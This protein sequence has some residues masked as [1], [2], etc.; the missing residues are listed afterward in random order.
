MPQLRTRRIIEGGIYNMRPAHECAELGIDTN[1]TAN[2]RD[3]ML[4]VI[5]KV[6][7]RTC[8]WQV[9]TSV[10][11]TS[12][13]FE[14]YLRIDKELYVHTDGLV[15]YEKKNGYHFQVRKKKSGGMAQLKVFLA[16][17][18]RFTVEKASQEVAARNGVP[19]NL[20]NGYYGTAIVEQLPEEV[21]EEI[22][23][24]SMESGK[25]VE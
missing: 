22:V 7:D 20:P 1:I 5:G 24:A 9:M 2:A 4:L 23:D 3:H 12:F 25:T 13:P 18:E 8:C 15:E 16:L 17:R 21:A 14:S 10:Y 19:G 11:M 6:P